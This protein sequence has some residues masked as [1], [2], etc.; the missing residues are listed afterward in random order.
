MRIGLLG[1]GEHFAIKSAAAGS[2]AAE[3]YGFDTYWVPGEVD[4]ISVIVSSAQRAEKIKFATS[5]I[6]VYSRHPVALAGEAIMTNEA[7]GGRLTLGIGMS[8]ANLVEAKWGR[9][10]DRPVLYV[11]E[12]LSILLSL[13]DTRSVDYDGQLFR[14]HTTFNVGA[15]RRP[16][17]LVAAMGP[18]MLKVTGQLADGTDTWMT[19]P[20][21]LETLTV[22][23][24]SSAAAAAGRPAP[25]IA[26]GMPVCVTS[27]ADEMREVA[28]TD[29]RHHADFPTYRRMLDL[30]G[31]AGPADVAVIGDE[32]GVQ[33]GL[34]RYRDVGVT[35]F[36]ACLFGSPEDRGHTLSALRDMAEQ[37]F[38]ANG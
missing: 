11:R 20:R 1:L 9:A 3:S 25:R 21:T 23:T 24:I 6:P 37:V 2:L 19:G 5:V 27:H 38:R 28:A 34:E 16:S 32:A 10:V 15:Q 4:P 18:Q 29:F 12:F 33:R 30:E 36:I 8:H 13:L 35:D 31:A 26:A 7:I 22:P 17:V 14:A